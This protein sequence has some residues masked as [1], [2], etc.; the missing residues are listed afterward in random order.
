[1][2][3]KKDKKKDEKVKFRVNVENEIKRDFI[4]FQ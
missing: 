3:E 2:N 4:P 1:M